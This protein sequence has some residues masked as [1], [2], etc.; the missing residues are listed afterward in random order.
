M[1]ELKGVT[2]KYQEQVIL[3]NVS[4]T[5]SNVGFYG[6][7]GQS[8]IGKTTFLN[9][10]GLLDEPG[11]GSILYDGKELKGLEEK[12]K[13]LNQNIAF[14][15]QELLLLEDMS[16]ME[17]LL[18]F[19]EDKD[20]I[21]EW[22][23]Y[24]H[25]EN[26][27][28][29]K[30]SKLSQG[31]KKRVAFIRTIFKPS[32]LYLFD[33]PTSF[34]DQE[35]VYKVLETLKRLSQNA[36]VFVV[37]HDVEEVR[38]YADVLLRLENQNFTVLKQ[39]ELVSI[40]VSSG[41]K[42]KLSFAKQVK[43]AFNQVIATPKKTI[44]ALLLTSFILLGLFTGI[45]LRRIDFNRIHYETLVHE[46]SEDIY[47][48]TSEYSV[49]EIT[50]LKGKYVTES[51]SAYNNSSALASFMTS[52]KTV[53][54]QTDNAY[55]S[56][57]MLIQKFYVANT[58]VALLLGR[59]PEQDNE[60]VIGKFLAD[61]F[62]EYGIMGIDEQVYYP[63]SY[64]E[65][66]NIENISLGG[67]PVRIVGVRDDLLEK[68]EGLKSISRDQMSEYDIK[69]QDDMAARYQNV[70][71]VY[72]SES[73]DEYMKNHGFLALQ[74]SLYVK[75]PK[76]QLKSFLSDYDNADSIVAHYITE[77][78]PLAKTLKI[79]GLV[80]LIVFAFLFVLNALYMM[81]N[82]ISKE[83]TKIMLLKEYGIKHRTILGIFL[84]EHVFIVL[85]S[86]LISFFLYLGLSYII[87]TLYTDYLL[88]YFHIFYIEWLPNL[89]LILFSLLSLF[90]VSLA[91][92]KEIKMKK[93]A[94]IE[95]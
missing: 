86:L 70:N 77:F 71:V 12:E 13:Y 46:K 66:L 72:V 38:G 67:V 55:Y 36:L 32:K 89:F 21:I 51:G 78:K 76:E 57:F 4:M 48:N 44:L 47:L 5:F 91:F 75:V 83:N 11:D 62:L 2:K 43:L 73:F 59:M 90:V 85:G 58:D 19:G 26:V 69:L 74:S 8:G 94:R 82:S 33:E 87:N 95:E 3:N 34:L 49:D 28:Q 16:V 39:S 84:M 27:C 79:I 9:L 42:V 50:S 92:K 1:I 29:E 68:Y 88:M 7:V 35:N 14:F 24:F 52:E 63:K 18:L 23:K 40:N 22:I 65:L 54:L 41:K 37:S 61:V 25:L 53:V 20:R 6:I 17:N 45:S 56:D 15:N 30:V 31:E 80:V 93:L 60:L 64:E 10:I 81:K